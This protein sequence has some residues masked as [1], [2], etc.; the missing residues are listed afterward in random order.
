MGFEVTKLERAS[1]HTNSFQFPHTVHF[2]HKMTG[3]IGT[4]A[5]PPVGD[6]RTL[7]RDH[8]SADTKMEK[9]TSEPPQI[10]ISTTTAAVSAAQKAQLQNATIQQ[11]QPQLPSGSEGPTMPLKSSPPVAPLQDIHHSRSP[12]SEAS[13]SHTMSNHGLRLSP[14]PTE[15]NP[16]TQICLCQQ[17]A[18]IPRPRNGKSALFVICLSELTAFPAAFILFRQ[19]HHA[20]VVQANPGKPNPEISKIIG[21][22]WRESSKETKLIWQKHADV[23]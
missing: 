4:D 1:L 7:L 21:E 13:P 8:N 2:R 15:H 22:M 5:P 9:A 6:L 12:A 14:L 17:P 18:R 10:D 23:S 16:P 3:T 20:S 19:H 11:D